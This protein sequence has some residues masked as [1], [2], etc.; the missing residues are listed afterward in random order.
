MAL[1][2]NP[3]RCVPA[4]TAWPQVGVAVVVVA[5][6]AMVVE[7][8]AAA[9]AEAA[10]VAAAAAAVP[11]VAAAETL[12]DDAEAT[13]PHLADLQEKWAAALYW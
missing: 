9:T 12:A 5:T 4:L 1:V 13:K 10:Q 8:A 6:V 7:V 2:A 3:T 11:R